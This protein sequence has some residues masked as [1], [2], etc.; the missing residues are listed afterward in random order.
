[1]RLALVAV[2]TGWALFA[3]DA[4]AET[5]A[6]ELARKHYELG[7]KL[8]EMSN[9]GEALVEFEKAYKLEPKPELLFN[10]A[11]C[12]E[13]MAQLDKAIAYYERY[14]QEYPEAPNRA[15][16]EARL[17]NLRKRRG[18]ARPADAKAPPP[19]PPPAVPRGPETASRWKW[20]TGWI[21]V[22]IGGASLVT[23]IVF[24]VLAKN[25]AD[26]FSSGVME[27]RPYQELNVIDES[28]K[29]YETLQIVTLAV[30]GALAAAGG[31]LLLWDVL[32]RR[33]RRA[34]LGIVPYADH[35]GVGV[36]GRCSF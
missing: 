4:H 2:I 15:V 36:T 19:A 25:K 16:V 18:Q 14:L 30:G 11:R 22:G 33:E 29:R 27:G 3:T 5:P 10:V 23:G 13:V 31:G 28:G 17:V 6:H 35:T 24:G 1:M 12:H 8:Y 32:G 21:A 20:T 34:S 7:S 9:Y 26:D